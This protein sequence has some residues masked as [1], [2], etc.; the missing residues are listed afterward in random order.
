M[1]SVKEV[2]D[3]ESLNED[4]KQKFN[5][6]KMKMF[7]MTILTCIIF[8][9]LAIALLF[10]MMF[11]K[12]GKEN[13]YN[14]MAYF[15]YTF[16]FGTLFVIFV[17]SYNIYTFKPTKV[18]QGMGYDSEICPDYWELEKEDADIVENISLENVNTN[19]FKYVCK[20]NPSI[21][22]KTKMI[23]DD[24]KLS[25]NNLVITEKKIND[26]EFKSPDE[27][28]KRYAN[29]MS[30]VNEKHF[31]SGEIE[32]PT[33]SPSTSDCGSEMFEIDN[34]YHVICD[35]VYPMFLSALDHQHAKE[36]NL[37]KSNKFRC[38]YSKVCKVPW[39]EAGCS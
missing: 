13:I 21:I 23:D 14:K 26:G 25:A 10:A 5:F 22:S 38:E 11:T 35:Q 18:K 8:S 9:I 30:H 1:T 32:T 39:T 3:I 33:P 29:V 19:H 4:E 7:K 6:T 27:E 28:F 16:V 31:E 12:W 17:L 24:L 34:K 20:V 37:S 36:N 2:V 15:V